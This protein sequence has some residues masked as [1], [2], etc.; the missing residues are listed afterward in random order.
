LLNDIILLLVVTRAF[1]PYSL[2]LFLF[3]R[4]KFQKILSKQFPIMKPAEKKTPEDPNSPQHLIKSFLKAK[5]PDQSFESD[6]KILAAGKVSLH[7]P[8]MILEES[9]KS[10]SS[11]IFEQSDDL[12]L[13][14]ASSVNSSVA[15]SLPDSFDVSH[16]NPLMFSPKTQAKF[17]A[18]VQK[19]S[20]VRDSSIYFIIFMA[21]LFVYRIFLIRIFLY[22]KPTSFSACLFSHISPQTSEYQKFRC[23]PTA[24]PATIATYHYVRSP[25]ITIS[26]TYCLFRRKQLF[27]KENEY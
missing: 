13:S 20:L 26:I 15:L 24:H 10:A 1:L 4:F 12:F 18:I 7:F 5:L 6:R 27:R 16:Q 17:D 14:E 19:K 8:S 3:F 22:C 11:N 21:N 9:T 23:F 2:E 25:S